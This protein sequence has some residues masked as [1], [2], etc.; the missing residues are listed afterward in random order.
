MLQRGLLKVLTPV[1]T[2]GSIHQDVFAFSRCLNQ[3]KDA[4]DKLTELDRSAG[5][6]ES[7]ICLINRSTICKTVKLEGLDA[8]VMYSSHRDWSVYTVDENGCLSISVEDILIL[9]SFR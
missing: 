7:F 4:F 3:G 9:K 1:N 2:D 5:Q 8:G 6:S